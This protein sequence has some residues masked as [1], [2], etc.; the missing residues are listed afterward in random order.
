MTFLESIVLGAVQGFT[1]FLPVSS[2]GHLVLGHAL[3]GSVGEDNLLFDVAVH[4][5][6]LAAVFVF[7]RDDLKKMIPAIPSFVGWAFKGFPKEQGTLVLRQM[8]AIVVTTIP[9]A[10]I[11]LAFKDTFE[12]LFDNLLG[13]GVGFLVTATLLTL[14]GKLASRYPPK[15]EGAVAEA[16]TTK[17]AFIIGLM[18]SV[19]ITPGISRSGSTVATALMLGVE[20]EM[21]A[22]HSFLCSIP[23]IIGA[24]LLTARKVEGATSSDLAMCGAG[25]VVSA[26]TGYFA[27]Q[28]L[29][30]FVKSGSFYKFAY[31]VAP[32][33]I[34]TIA[35][36]LLG[37]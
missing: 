18:Q 26:F 24:A 7:Y 12:A 6:T 34:V 2:S 37:K 13:V 15:A 3:F 17:Q 29:T 30:R 22:R 36:A 11:G 19:A 9:T 25:L 21:A 28:L 33:G 27:L 35:W 1:E 16:P 14:S 10:I 4:L 31:Y 32:L 5:G 20:R 23:A 8:L